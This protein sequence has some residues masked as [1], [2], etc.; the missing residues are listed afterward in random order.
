MLLGW[1]FQ[2]ELHLRE[3]GELVDT[4]DSSMALRFRACF[5]WRRRVFCLVK[6]LAWF[7]RC[8]DGRRRCG[9]LAGERGDGLLP[10]QVDIERWAGEGAIST[11]VSGGV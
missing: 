2:F 3:K 8:P 11:E 10:A 6:T 4:L 7:W 9:V 5:D 1:V